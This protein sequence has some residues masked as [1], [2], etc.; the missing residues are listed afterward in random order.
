MNYFNTIGPQ[1][2]APACSSVQGQC[3]CYYGGCTDNT[4]LNYDPA[5]TCDDGS[6]G[7]VI[8]QG[9]T[10]P[11]SFNYN[12]Q[13]NTDDG[14]CV[15]VVTGCMDQTASNYNPSANTGC[16]GGNPPGPVPTPPPAPQAFD[17]SYQNMAGTDWQQ[18]GYSGTD[19]QTEYSNLTGT[20]WQEAGYEGT[21]WQDGPYGNYSGAEVAN[22][23]GGPTIPG[24][25]WRTPPRS[26]AAF[27]DTKE[28]VS[29]TDRDYRSFNEEGFGGW[30]DTRHQAGFVPNPNQAPYIETTE[31]LGFRGDPRY[32][33]GW[34]PPRTA[35]MAAN[36]YNTQ[37]W[38]PDYDTTYRSRPA[39]MDG[40]DP[41][42]RGT[43]PMDYS[44]TM[45]HDWI[46][47]YE[48]L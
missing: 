28:Y 41:Y 21:S 24:F 7:A 18:E 40:F 46:A 14:S 5:A 6:C 44:N 9:C 35:Q 3:P 25:F 12:P 39:D 38:E 43:E 8:V 4:K 47:G 11:A 17:G 34:S 19:W 23:A 26:Q 33:E 30:N 20:D 45:P 42:L 16:A 22:A 1:P 36:K 48:D 10:D 29:P 37:P 2:G 32:P 13:A 27:T 31:H 15:A